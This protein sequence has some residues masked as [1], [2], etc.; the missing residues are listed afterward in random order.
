[1]FNGGTM[2]AAQ[3]CMDQFAVI[4]ESQVVIQICGI[5][6]AGETFKYLDAKGGQHWESD[7]S[8]MPRQ[9]K[10]PT[11]FLPPAKDKMF[12][13]VNLRTTKIDHYEYEWSGNQFARR[14]PEHDIA[15]QV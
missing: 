9:T 10:C 4:K 1:M 3:F 13:Y 11:F 7:L 14:C 2:T 6:R 12:A 5:V 8:E 15:R